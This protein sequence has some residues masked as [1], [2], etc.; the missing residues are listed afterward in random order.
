MQINSGSLLLVSRFNLAVGGHY[1]TQSIY[2]L[3]AAV[4]Y[5]QFIT[6]IYIFFMVIGDG[7]SCS[8]NSLPLHITS[9]VSV[10][11]TDFWRRS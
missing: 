8:W 3:P 11:C 7:G 6:A 1:L 9:A 10:E 4:Q 5:R 2:F